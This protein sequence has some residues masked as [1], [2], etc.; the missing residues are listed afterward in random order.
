MPLPTD[1]GV[2]GA[3]YETGPAVRPLARRQM[4]ETL[5]NRAARSGQHHVRYSK[6]CRCGWQ[7][8]ELRKYEAAVAALERHQ[9]K[10][11][12]RQPPPS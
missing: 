12:G 2:D 11:P 4:D 8:A 5:A 3:A 7:T 10:C 9:Q 1:Y 6:R